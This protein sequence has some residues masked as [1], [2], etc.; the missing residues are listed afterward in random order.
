MHL[1]GAEATA[2]VAGGAVAAVGV[3]QLL[4]LERTKT[5]SALLGNLAAYAGPP[6]FANLIE[7]LCFRAVDKET[8]G[9]GSTN[10]NIIFP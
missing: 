9:N 5:A 8:M 7:L 2:A 4:T 6:I 10:L 1:S 3:K